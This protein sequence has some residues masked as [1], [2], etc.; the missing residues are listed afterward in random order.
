MAKITISHLS[1]LLSSL[2]VLAGPK[3][4]GT[5]P[6]IDVENILEPTTNDSL[7]DNIVKGYS[8]S[9]FNN[10]A[11][12]SKVSKAQLK[13]QRND[14]VTNQN[15]KVL[16]TLGGLFVYNEASDTTI[17]FVSLVGQVPANP[18]V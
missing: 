10:H 18:D 2:F 7:L 12:Y 15:C 9:S 1:A 8:T 5:L 14:L 16:A 13:N 4:L 3:K 17:P 6:S 11:H